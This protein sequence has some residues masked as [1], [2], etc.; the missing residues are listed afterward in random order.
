MH[1]SSDDARK[2]EAA[3]RAANVRV[4]IA[5]QPGSRLSLEK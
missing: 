3:L 1:A 4:T 5:A 2:V